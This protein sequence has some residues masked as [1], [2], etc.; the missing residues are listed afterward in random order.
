MR[1][2][3][4]TTEAAIYR[5]L[6]RAMQ[7]R[8]AADG[9]PFI[10]GH[11]VTNRCLCRCA[12]C[13]WRDNDCED[14]PLDNLRRFYAQASEQGFVATAMTGGEPFMRT[15]L[16]D[17]VRFVKQEA[18]MSILVFNT[19]W[20][21]KLRMDEVLPHI[22]MMIVSLDS[23][24]PERHDEIRG[25]PGLFDRAT[26]GV[27]LVRQNYPD[28]S[29]QFNTCV[30][31]GIA[32]E[33]DALLDLAST[34]DV[35]ISFDV[36]TDYRHGEDEHFTETSMGLPLPE[37]R[38]VCASLLE[39]KR[40]GAPILN[41]EPYFEYFVTGKPGY[42]CHL[43][44][45]VMFVDGWGNAEYC[46]NLDRPIANI[47]DTSVAEIMAMPRFKQLRADAE[48]CHSCNSPTMIDLS[49]VWENPALAV[50]PG[51]IALG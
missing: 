51:G 6:G 41:S 21:L 25:L 20:Y 48:S 50:G 47:R 39:K 14:V 22:D 31:Q 44:K 38:E 45:L 13:L 33:I 28:V 11:H 2:L 1:K 12:S 16:G 10:V 19:G 15:D 4:P 18:G 34:L 27:R 24:K 9:R 37:L 35:Q 43:P 23:A 46:L 30:Q 36:I 5:V 3:T 42:R 7:A 17:L 40:A 49:A 26:E 8:Q 32:G 29:L